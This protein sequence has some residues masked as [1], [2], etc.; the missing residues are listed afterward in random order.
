[1]KVNITIRDIAKSANV[2]HTTVSRALSDSSLVTEKTKIKIKELARQ[3]GYIPNAVA[4]GLATNKTNTIGMII[5]DIMNP[6]Y[7]EVAKGLKDYANREGFNVFLCDTD[8]DPKKEQ[9][10]IDELYSQRVGGVIISPVSEDLTHVI[11]KYPPDGPLVFLSYQPD[12]ANCSYVVTDPFR[13]TYIGTKHLIKLGHKKIAF[14]GYEKNIQTT[15]LRYNGYKTA[16]EESGLEP[17]SSENSS[18]EI[19]ENVGYELTKELLLKDEIP[20]AILAYNDIIALGAMEAAE[21]F[22]LQVPDNLSVMGIDNISISNLYRIHL[23]TVSQDRFKLGEWCAKILIDKIRNPENRKSIQ[24]VLEPKLV[25]RK[26]C[27]ALRE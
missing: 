8:R 23:T 4:K 10:Y 9:N 13:I 21:E 26:T 7:S 5:P 17:F 22:G 1:L 27:K 19:Y 12:I 14:I 3:M 18:Y 11:S 25:I 15:S 24:K 2:S 16:L 6:Y 20:T